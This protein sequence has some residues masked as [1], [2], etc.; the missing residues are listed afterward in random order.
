MDALLAEAKAGSVGYAPDGR[1]YSHV[2]DYIDATGYGGIDVGGF[3]DAIPSSYWAEAHMFADYLNEG[4]NAE[5]LHLKNIAPECG[6]NPYNA[7]PGAIVVVAAGAPGTAHPTAG[8]IAVKG[9]GDIFYNGGEMSY[10]PAA[11]FPTDKTLGIYVPVQCHETSNMIPHFFSERFMNSDSNSLDDYFIDVPYMN[12]KSI[13][14]PL[15]E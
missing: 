9:E 6:N 12:L 14:D 1:C 4:D 5:D 13:L 8:D 15:T 10:G 2:A 3:N 11:S 7:P